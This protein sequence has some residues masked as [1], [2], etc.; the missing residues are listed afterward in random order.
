MELARPKRSVGANSKSADS[1]LDIAQAWMSALWISSIVPKN[2]K[3][4]HS[5]RP[6]LEVCFPG[7]NTVLALFDTGADVSI[8]AKRLFDKFAQHLQFSPIIRHWPSA[9][10]RSATGNVVDVLGKTELLLQIGGKIV[11]HEFLVVT[12]V[13]TSCILGIDFMHKNGIILDTGR[14]SLHW[15][16]SSSAPPEVVTKR[17]TIVPPRSVK[18]ISANVQGLTAMKSDKMQWVFEP[19]GLYMTESLVLCNDDETTSVLAQ[20][21]TDYPLTYPRG[22]KLGNL[23]QAEIASLETLEKLNQNS[24]SETSSSTV[25]PNLSEIP[26]SFHPLYLKLLKE[27]PDVFSKDNFDVGHTREFPQKLILKD[28]TKIACTPPYRIPEHLRPVAQEYIDNLA[29]AGVIQKSSSPFSSPL[30]LVRKGDATADKPLSEQYRVVHDYRR[31]NDNTVK[32]SYPMRNLYELLDSVAHA[33]VWSVID[34]SSGFWNQTLEEGSR[35][36][37]AFGLPGCGHWEYTRSAQGLSNSPATFQRLLDHILQGIP[38]VHVYIDDVIVCAMDHPTHLQ[39]L[40]EVF[41]RF[42]KYHL[43]CKKSKLQLGAAQVNYL[44]YNISKEHGIRAGAAKIEVVRGWKPP[45]SVTEIKQFLGLCSFFRRTIPRFAEIASPLTRLT[46]KDADWQPPDLPAEAREAFEKLKEAL[47][48]RPCLAPVNF[49]K[50]FY[51]TTDASL[52]GLGAILSQVGEDGNEHPCAYASRVC[53]E[54]EAK[55]AP[56]HLEHLGMVWACRHFRPYLAGRHFTLRT[57]HKPLT[58]LNRIQG[59][60]LER[61]RAELDDY[62][63]FTVQYLKGDKMPADG[64]SR[65]SLE[66]LEAEVRKVPHVISHDQLYH[67]QAQDKEVKGL[68]CFLKFQLTPKDAKLRAYVQGLSENSIMKK[69]IVYVK[70]NGLLRALVPE[71]MKASLLFHSHD[72]P[73]AGHRSAQETL[74]KLKEAWYWPSMDAEVE[75]HCRGCPICLTVNRPPHNQPSPMGKLPIANDFNERVHMDLLGPM[76]LSQGNKYLLVMQDAHSK[77]V[78]LTPLTDKTAEATVN[79]IMDCW[80]SRHGAPESLVSDQGKEFVNSILA[81]VCKKLHVA[82]QT[83]SAMHPQANG[84]VERTNS[85]IISYLRKFLSGSNEWV[86]HLASL[87]FSLNTATHSSMGRTPYMVVYGRRPKVPLEMTT[88]DS[89]PR[90]SEQPIEQRLRNQAAIQKDVIESEEAAWAK[91]K[92]RFDAHSRVKEIKVG[93]MVYLNR[94]HVGKQ[95]Q[96][97]QPRFLGPYQVIELRPNDSVVLIRGDGKQLHVH[98]NR[99]KLAPFVQQMFRRAE[100]PDIQISTP[101]PNLDDELDRE[102]NLLSGD[103]DAATRW[104]RGTPGQGPPPAPPVVQRPVQAT[105]PARV[106]PAPPQAPAVPPPSTRAR[107]TLPVIGER[108]TAA[109]QPVPAARPPAAAARP[110]ATAARP[111]GPMPTASGA[112]P[113]TTSKSVAFRKVTLVT[114]PDYIP[115]KV[116]KAKG[117][118]D[119]V[120]DRLSPQHKGR[121]TRQAVQE[122]KADKP[123]PLWPAGKEARATIPDDEPHEEEEEEQDETHE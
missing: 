82:H 108:G 2:T 29:K 57:D 62:Q 26:S 90:Y 106:R 14:K 31:L 41:M 93:D 65:Q 20:N 16:R 73:L 116:P 44:G 11:K 42:R 112:R 55:W 100:G 92:S 6:K 13:K 72:S 64:L 43:K 49:D 101:N 15:P 97:F 18:R 69:G 9:H 25:Q 71:S 12:G 28:P 17:Q 104:R 40:K 24:K 117:F 10:L 109:R 95:F 74:N 67:L 107:P 66:E 113:K 33:K 58:S 47:C 115:A 87:Q 60:A 48:S 122:G 4:S 110:P 103:D 88:P 78:E 89:H 5:A 77:W 34:L 61:L 94:P 70:R 45:S 84:Q 38:G 76:P 123:P 50:E 79:G 7:K 36:Y 114:D 81:A 23:Y 30:M 3:L 119:R 102:K 111:R 63:P 27:F 85:S 54:A 121:P 51:L 8:I 22:A 53:T 32:D 39:R 80:I 37:T 46:R 99:I 19:D 59:Q 118:I 83:T 56:T 98:S 21:P 1:P 86:P 91:Q 96:K 52:K 75:A 68:A 35:P 120:K 105:L